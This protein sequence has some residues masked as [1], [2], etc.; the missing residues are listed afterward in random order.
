MLDLARRWAASASSSSAC[1][2]CAAG[3]TAR[4]RARAFA[5]IAETAIAALLPRV[6]AEF[7]QEPRPRCQA[8][9]IVVLGLGKL[10]SREMT[11]TSDLDLILV[12]DAPGAVEASDG[13]AA[14]RRLDLLRAA[15]RSASSTR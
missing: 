2:C 12:Y 10:G 15:L 14:A 9:R 8:A 7:A 11:V 6:A 1:S 5:D 13:R 3:S 4:R